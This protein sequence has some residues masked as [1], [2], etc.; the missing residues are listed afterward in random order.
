MKTHDDVPKHLLAYPR[1]QKDTFPLN[2]ELVKHV[3]DIATK[4][5]ITPSQLAINWARAIGR[6]TGITIIPIPGATTAPRVDENSKLVDLSDAE[7][8]ELNTIL[9]KI[10]VVGSRYPAYIP[11]DG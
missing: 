5:G 4:K 6:K 8:D 9:E 7:L 1:Y 10:Q 11:M 3:E 2:L